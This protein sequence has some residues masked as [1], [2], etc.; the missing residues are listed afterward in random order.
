MSFRGPLDRHLLAYLAD[1][2]PLL[3]SLHVAPAGWCLPEADTDDSVITKL[4]RLERLV[5]R[6][7]IF[8]TPTLR[9]LLKHCP[10]PA[11]RCST[12]GTATPTG[13]LRTG[14]GARVIG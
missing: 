1:R 9:A 4:P 12:S 2:A 6:G 3:R 8:R 5:L 10:L 7:G 14:Y 13:A 11:S